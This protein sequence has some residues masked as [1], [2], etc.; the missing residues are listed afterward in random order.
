EIM[1][2]IGDVNNKR[3]ILVDDLIDTGGT[4]INAANA[5]TEMG[6]KEVY[7]CCTHGVLS[8]NAVER[9]EKSELKE[10]I[11][12]NTIPL[13]EEKRSPK[14]KSLSVAPVFAEAIERIYGDMSISTL[15]TQKD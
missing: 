1:N 12:L 14:I 11:T 5:L 9:I 6:A 4:I 2:I 7:A 15:F 10:L 8:G 3:V 13:T